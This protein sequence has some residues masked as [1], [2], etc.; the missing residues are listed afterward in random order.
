MDMVIF[1]I[2][3]IHNMLT[4]NQQEKQNLLLKFDTLSGFMKTSWFYVW[5]SHENTGK[6]YFF[7]NIILNK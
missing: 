2:E 3:Q 7:Y 4:L 1:L 6:N 5:N